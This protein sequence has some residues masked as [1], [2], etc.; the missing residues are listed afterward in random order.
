MINL[1]LLCDKIINKILRIY[2]VKVFE[3]YTGQKTNNLKILG[4]VTLIN[5]NIKVGKNVTIFP[6]VMLFGDGPIII[7]DNVDIG[8]N[9]IIYAADKY[10]GV[11]IGNN[12]M[13]AANNYII[14][15]NHG[16]KAGELI[17]NQANESSPVVIGAD[18]WIATGCQVIKGANIGDG[19]V[20]GAGSL[21]N[22]DIPGGVIAFGTPASPYKV[23]S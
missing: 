20:I 18:V 11:S 21:V 12:S 2:R 4:K 6:N 10:G 16:I 9:T 8:N 7:G 23:R 13:I 17:R 5:N 1:F 3:A 22:K 15:T 19:T 14:D